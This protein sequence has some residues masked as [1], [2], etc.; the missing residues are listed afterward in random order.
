MGRFWHL[1]KRWNFGRI[2]FDWWR[3]EWMINIVIFVGLPE[4]PRCPRWRWCW[5]WS[6]HGILINY[7]KTQ[8]IKNDDDVKGYSLS[9]Q[10]MHLPRLQ[11]RQRF[12]AHWTEPKCACII[13]TLLC[14]CNT[15]GRV[16]RSLW[17]LACFC[18]HTINSDNKM[19]TMP[20]VLHKQINSIWLFLMVSVTGIVPKINSKTIIMA[21]NIPKR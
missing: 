13:I 19:V 20:N 6:V 4:Q 16:L 14:F 17:R 3:S 11:S 2:M 9:I 7:R 15:N 5:H 8:H 10:T 1:L 21:T 18:C 12:I